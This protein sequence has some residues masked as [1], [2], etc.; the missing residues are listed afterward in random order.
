MIQPKLTQLTNQIV[1]PQTFP[2]IVRNRSNPCR[3]QTYRPIDLREARS[4]RFHDN[5]DNRR[6]TFTSVSAIE[7]IADTPE[8]SAGRHVETTGGSLRVSFLSPP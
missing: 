2:H 3:V 6:T 1:I 8:S 7:T 5:C 4:A